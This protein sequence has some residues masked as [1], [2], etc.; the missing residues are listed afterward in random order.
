M[1]QQA[2]ENMKDLGAV[3]VRVQQVEK[4][5]STMRED[6]VKVS[7]RVL[8]IESVMRKIPPGLLEIWTQVETQMMAW[9]KEEKERKDKVKELEVASIKVKESI[10]K[11]DKLHLENEKAHQ[12]IKDKINNIN[13]KSFEDDVRSMEEEMENMKIRMVDDMKDLHE[14]VRE[15][16][17]S[18]SGKD[19]KSERIEWENKVKR[20]DFNKPNKW[21]ES[22]KQSTFEQFTAAV[23]RWGHKLHDDF[24]NVLIA[25]ENGAESKD[26]DASEFRDMKMNL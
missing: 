5:E 21:S 14:Q 25:I 6:Y 4:V 17:Y 26:W 12:D 7:K 10:E 24:S 19:E 11:M 20:A 3:E 1:E 13:I 18:G 8:T 23:K 22:D 9:H 16:R 2:N 15:V